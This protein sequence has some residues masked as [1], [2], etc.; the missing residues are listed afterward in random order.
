MKSLLVCIATLPAGSFA[1]V[2]SVASPP[3]PPTFAKP[4]FLPR[5]T[6]AEPTTTERSTSHIT[7]RRSAKYDLGLGKNLPVKAK[8]RPTVNTKQSTQDA[9]SY[10]M[11]P[12]AANNYPSPLSQAPKLKRIKTAQVIPTRMAEDVVAISGTHEAATAVLR[13]IS[14]VDLDVNTL[15]VEMLIHQQ[16]NK[17]M[18]V[19]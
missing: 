13:G 1:Y 3:G 10:W 17:M 2:A 18:A 16:Q 8:K 15:W 9:V 4:T 5:T 6:T 7:N 14:T 12:E 11:I 19:A